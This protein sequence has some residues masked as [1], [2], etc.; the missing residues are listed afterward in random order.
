MT[1][2]I[3]ISAAVAFYALSWIFAFLRRREASTWALLISTGLG[4]AWSVV[5]RFWILTVVAAVAVPLVVAALVKVRRE[6]AEAAR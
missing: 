5:D 3:L 1:A 4:L 2:A 6:D